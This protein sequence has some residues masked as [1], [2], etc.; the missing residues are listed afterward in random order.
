VISS[1][2]A[3]PE[4]ECNPA[5]IEQIFFILIQNAVQAAN[6]GKANQLE[7][8]FSF[9]NNALKI[10][11]SDNCCGIEDEHLPRIFEPFFT[12][13]PAGQGTGLGLSIAKR[14]VEKYGGT[15]SVISKPGYGSTFDVVFPF[16]DDTI[17]DGDK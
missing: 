17:M 5:E 16:A 14:I 12:T 11:F 1:D 4:M 9:K 6:P 8:T 13:K 2:G 3:I 7:I 15:I 10:S